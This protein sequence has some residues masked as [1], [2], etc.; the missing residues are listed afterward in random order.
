MDFYSYTENVKRVTAS[1]K[2]KQI[3]HRVFA[4]ARK[5]AAFKSE[6]RSH[7]REVL[8]FKLRQFENVYYTNLLCKVQSTRTIPFKIR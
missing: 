3:T 4:E 2:D 6:D 1:L 5:Q 8:P 7:F